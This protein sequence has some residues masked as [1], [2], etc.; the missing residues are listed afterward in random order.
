M[1]IKPIT[2]YDHKILTEINRAFHGYVKKGN[3]DPSR[4][5][6]IRASGLPFCVRHFLLRAS[7]PTSDLDAFGAFFTSVG[8]T[9][10][11]WVQDIAGKTQLILGDWHN[12]KT[13]K[14]RRFSLHPDPT[15]QD[16]EYHELEAHALGAV[17]HCDGIFCLD[18]KKAMRANRKKNAK[19]RLQAFIDLQVPLFVLDYKTCTIAAVPKKV[20][21]SG[22]AYVLQLLFYCL[23][24]HKLGLNV[25]GYGNFYI[26]R[27]NPSKWDMNAHPW[28][29]KNRKYI[30]KKIKGWV[31]LH[32]RSRKAKTWKQFKSLYDEG[33]DCGGIYCNI[34]RKRNPLGIL[35]EAYD[36]GS[37]PL[38][39]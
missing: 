34:C 17:G 32:A 27:D 35:R 2:K 38:D 30:T 14:W 10:H 23:A 20:K 31:D 7:Q 11:T 39:K 19:A 6:T 28:T 3:K 18:K 36:A 26:P 29:P 5:K 33:G 12:K 8:T 9:V 15:S 24:F 13:D 1:L 22:E 25:K 21:E 37:W 16:W 4:E